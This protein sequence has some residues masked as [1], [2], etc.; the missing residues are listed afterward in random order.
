MEH[1]EGGV[2]YAGYDP[3]GH[4]GLSLLFQ[5]FLLDPPR[6]LPRPHRRNPLYAA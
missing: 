3:R 5:R 6:L 2:F 4:D 1:T